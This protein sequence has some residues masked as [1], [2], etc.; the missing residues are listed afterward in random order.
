MAACSSF[1]AVPTCQTAGLEAEWPRWRKLQGNRLGLAATGR[2]RTI[3]VSRGHRVRAPARIA[4]SRWFK[5][6]DHRRRAQLCQRRRGLESH[7]GR[8]CQRPGIGEPIEHAPVPGWACSSTHRWRCTPRNPL[9]PPPDVLASS[10]LPPARPREGK[11]GPGVKRPRR[12]RSD[13]PRL[14]AAIPWSAA[15]SA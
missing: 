12:P 1:G 13:R 3:T 9:P 6:A 11:G 7:R 4:P 14:S 8:F 10:R 15:S 5:I 2:T